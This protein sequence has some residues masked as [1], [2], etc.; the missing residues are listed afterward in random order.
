MLTWCWSMAHGNVYWNQSIQSMMLINNILCIKRTKSTFASNMIRIY[1]LCMHSTGCSFSILRS[2]S[3]VAYRPMGCG[4]TDLPQLFM[5]GS[6]LEDAWIVYLNNIPFKW[7]PVRQME[8]NSVMA[9]LCSFYLE[10]T[11][12]FKSQIC[13]PCAIVCMQLW[14]LKDATETESNKETHIDKIRE[15]TKTVSGAHTHSCTHK[16]INTPSESFSIIMLLLDYIV[17]LYSIE[18]IYA[19]QTIMN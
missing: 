14:N 11:V 3:L 8:T 6:L 10:R 16:Q 18:K 1:T 4:E 5:S 9:I 2:Q 12:E 17:D 19:W 7:Q 13:F 15:R